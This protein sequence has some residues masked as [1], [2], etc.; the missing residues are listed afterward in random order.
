MRPA[1]AVVCGGIVLFAFPASAEDIRHGRELA[2]RFCSHCHVIDDHNPFGGIGS[3]PSF[4]LLA[5]MKDG[6]ERFRSFFTRRPHPSFVR[7]PDQRPPTNL[8]LNAPPV[9]ITYEQLH[10]IVDY[11]LTLKN[12]RPAK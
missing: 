3:T 5:T 8:P 12:S 2:I 11:A 4:R 9:E 6:A 10:E 7:L 1:V